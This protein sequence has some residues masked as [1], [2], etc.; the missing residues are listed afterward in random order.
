MSI[1]PEPVMTFP[2]L[3]QAESALDWIGLDFTEGDGFFAGELDEDAVELLDAAFGD[4]DT[5]QAVRALAA[6]LREQWRDAT[7]P[8]T[9]SV[10]FES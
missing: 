4:D 7:A 10:A 1:T 5:P 6:V 2:N 8:R 9:W 3:D